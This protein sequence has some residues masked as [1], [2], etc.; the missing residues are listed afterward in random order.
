MKNIIGAISVGILL[1]GAALAADL[2]ENTRLA[3]LAQRGDRSG[4]QALLKQ[5]VDVNAPQG[6]GMTALHWAALKNDVVLA[7][8]LLAAG[9][10][11][12]A[13]T[14]VEAL[15]PLALAAKEG[16]AGVIAALLDAKADPNLPNDLGA[17][18]LMLAAASGDVDCVNALLLSARRCRRQCEGKSAWANRSNVRSRVQSRPGDSDPGGEACGFERN[19]RDY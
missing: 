2:N 19:Q 17:T 12:K 6:D 10:D 4:V 9:A 8:L 5:K 7:Q 3:N 11:S 18:P 15:T 14:R 16:H 13:T 1:L